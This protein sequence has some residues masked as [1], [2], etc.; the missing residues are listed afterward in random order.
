MIKAYRSKL[1]RHLGNRIHYIPPEAFI[2]GAILADARTD[3]YALGHMLYELETGK[4]FREQQGWIPFKSKLLRSVVEYIM[5]SGPA[6]DLANSSNKM[7]PNSHDAI[8]QMV[9][10]NVDERIHS[11]DEII[12]LLNIK[13]ISLKQN[14]SDTMGFPKFCIES[15][16]NRGACLALNLVDGGLRMIGRTDIAGNKLS[17]SRQHLRVMR[18]G[19]FFMIDD[20]GSTKGTFLNGLR[21]K[22]R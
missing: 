2:E 9:K 10:H 6:I 4:R 11:I 17:I 14:R 22:K 21:L 15:G 13:T 1:E 19:H 3:I 18:R 8:A 16:D 20:N 5:H 12:K 7:Y